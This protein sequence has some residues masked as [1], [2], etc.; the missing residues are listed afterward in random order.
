[1]VRLDDTVL[2]RSGDRKRPGC[3]A[4]WDRE[5]APQGPGRTSLLCRL[6]LLALR[7]TRFHVEV[8]W[9]EGGRCLPG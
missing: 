4:P 3:E 1:M 8:L 2:G 5:A 6:L 9:T 7:G